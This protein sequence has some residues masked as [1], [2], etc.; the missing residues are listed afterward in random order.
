MKRNSSIKG[1]LF[2]RFEQAPSK[3]LDV[4]KILS[5]FRDLGDEFKGAR[6]KKKILDLSFFLP[7]HV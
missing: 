3:S 7:R 4:Q 5:R 2:L 6:G 1:N